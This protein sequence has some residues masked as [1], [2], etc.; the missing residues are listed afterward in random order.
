MRNRFRKQTP[1]VDWDRERERERVVSYLIGSNI[2]PQTTLTG[3]I[4]L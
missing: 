2:D 3:N 1:G 4:I